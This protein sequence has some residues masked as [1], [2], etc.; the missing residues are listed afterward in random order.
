MIRRSRVTPEEVPDILRFRPDDPILRKLQICI[1]AEMGIRH[2]EI[3]SRYKVSLK[4]VYNLCQSFNRWG[5]KGLVDKSKPGRSQSLSDEEKRL[6][7]S[8]KAKDSAISCRVIQERLQ[9][10][11]G[12]AGSAKAIERFLKSCGLGSVQGRGV[13]KTPVSALAEKQ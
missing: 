1:A 3:A 13:K 11:T 5:V 8:F 12:F 2:H 10:K 6:C 7:L 4:T 9:A